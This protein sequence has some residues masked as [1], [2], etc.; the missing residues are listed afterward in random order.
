MIP[1]GQ[2]SP[3]EQGF[4]E[5]PALVALRAWHEGVPARQAVSRYL[6]DKKATGASS[7]AMLTR[8]CAA[9]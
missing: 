1:G 3:P 2:R 4:P 5:A 8:A 9:S 6:G 7:R